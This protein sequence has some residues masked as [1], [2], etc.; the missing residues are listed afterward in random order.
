MNCISIKL[1]LKCRIGIGEK[2]KGAVAAFSA[3]NISVGFR[4]W[5]PGATM[6]ALA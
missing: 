4:G 1:Y 3:L 6:K 5:V 2:E